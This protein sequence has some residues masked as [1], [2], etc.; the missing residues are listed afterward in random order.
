MFKHGDYILRE[1]LEQLTLPERAALVKSF[2][3]S[4]FHLH[5]AD[6]NGWASSILIPELGNAI[7]PYPYHNT[8]YWYD[9]IPMYFTNELNIN[10]VRTIIKLTS[11]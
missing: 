6:F 1:T 4:N 9:D 11:F 3:F 8:V 2:K 10:E 5:D 7:G